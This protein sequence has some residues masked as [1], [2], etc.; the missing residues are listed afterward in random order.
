M[1]WDQMGW[2]GIRF[3]VVTKVVSPKFDAKMNGSFKCNQCHYAT[4]YGTN[5]R[6]YLKS[7]SG[8]K[9]YI[10]NQCQRKSVDG[11]IENSLRRKAKQLQSMGLCSYYQKQF[12]SSLAKSLYRKFT[13][14]QP[15]R[16][17]ICL[18]NQL[19]ESFENSLCGENLQ[20]QP[21]WLCLYNC[22]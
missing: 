6:R 12:E 3:I 16:F 22:T 14:M 8:E 10:W 17:C 21:M 9:S 11:T 1:G 15:M 19:E 18:G 13:R 4:S 20:M 5:I 7:H 2:D